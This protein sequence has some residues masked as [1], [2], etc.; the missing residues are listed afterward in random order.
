MSGKVV[1]VVAVLV[2]AT[3]IEWREVDTGNTLATVV[4]VVVVLVEA[5]DTV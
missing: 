1:T 2:D 5:T 3:D 4:V